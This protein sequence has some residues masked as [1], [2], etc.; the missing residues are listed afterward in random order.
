M[1]FLGY[2][3]LQYLHELLPKVFVN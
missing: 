1:A 2:W 3:I